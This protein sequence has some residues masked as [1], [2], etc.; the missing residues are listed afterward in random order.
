MFTKSDLLPF[1]STDPWRHALHTPWNDGG[2]TYAT[3]GKILLR[4][5]AIPECER[6]IPIPPEITP[7]TIPDA[8]TPAWQQ[9]TLPEG[10][11][12]TPIN[13]IK[14]NACLGTGKIKECPTCEG[15]GETTC[16][17]CGHIKRC[18]DCEGDGTLVGSGNNCEGCDGTGKV[19]GETLVPFLP[20]LSLR[21]HHLKLISTLP[22]WTLRHNPNNPTLRLDFTGGDGAIMAVSQR[23]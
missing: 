1:C 22:N 23:H 6:G 3:D 8:D 16:C 19:E 14:C 9:I 17:E 15:H 4:L 2:H 21:L 11:Q 7:G 20:G 12:E 5:P 18:D 13:I 10:W